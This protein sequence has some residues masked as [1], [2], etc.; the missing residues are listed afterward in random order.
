MRKKILCCVLAALMCLWAL[1]ILTGCNEDAK[2]NAVKNGNDYTI[3]CAYDETEHKLSAVQTVKV[4]N[5]SENSFAALKFHIYANQ[6]REDAASG[7]VPKTYTAIAYP[8]G[9]S[10]GE[11]SF[12]SVKADGT[13]VAFAI[14]GD[15]ADILSVPLAE[16]LFPDKSVTVE[17]VY[18]VSLANIKHRLG[19]T[20]NAVN[21]GNFYPI[22]CRVKNGNFD[23]TPYYNIGD[24]F[25]SDCANYKVSLKI[26]DDFVVA[27]T[28]NLAEASTSDGFATYTFEADAVRD[29][30]IVAS[31]KFKKLSQTVGDTTVNYFYFADA[32]AETSLST[33]VGALKYYNEHIGNYPYE[34][35]SVCETDFCYGG[36]EYPMLVMITS[37]TQAYSEAIAHE[38]AHQWFYAAVGNDQIADAWMD[39]GLAEFVT[40]LYLNSANDGQ[41]DKYIF[42]N[43]KIY[44]TY[45]DVL[46][47]FYDH[48]DTTYRALPDYKNDNEYVVMTYIKGS[49]MFSTL[50]ETM[51]ETKFFKA[52]KNYYDEAKFDVA[53]PSQMI[54][55]FTNV[56]GTEIGTVFTNFAEGKE[57]LGKITD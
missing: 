19:W 7:V 24:P 11:I 53:V 49:L 54:Q 36:M 6:Y 20:E 34:Q 16:E 13:A 4:T 57:I 31:V 21:L 22:L 17:M 29:F 18:T 35:L 30:A 42:D 15:D 46:T 47:N 43:L 48:V 45:V 32:D 44:T 56:G 5:R 8:S 12:D 14:E 41:L 38:V 40:Y 3:V 10:Y 2:Q 26:A 23:C 1:V 37:G 39:E 9:A 27:S 33:A 25:V 28:G 55:C 50:Y 52:L 51:G